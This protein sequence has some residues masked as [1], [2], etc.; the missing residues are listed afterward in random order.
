[1]KKTTS[2][3][4]IS[5]IIALAFILWGVVF[6]NNLDHVTALIQGFL[7]NQ[8]GWFYLLAAT[9]FVAFSIYLIFSPYGRIKLG[10]PDEKPQYSFLT[11]F[12]F[13]FTAGMGIGLVFWGAAEPI[14]HF[15]TPFRA[16]PDTNQAAAEAIQYSMFHWGIH[17]WA[18]YSVVA[19]CLA[20]F[21]FRKDEPAIFSSTLRPIAGNRVDGGLGTTI[22]V[23]VVIA[24]IFGVATSL[25]FGA[26][27][28]SG[29]LGFL[30]PAITNM[31]P[32][33]LNL[34]V[35]IVVTILFSVSAI[36]G[37]DKGIRYLSN[38]NVYLAIALM[39]FI[40]FAGSTAYMMGVFTQG[41]GNYLQNFINM[42][43]SLDIYDSENTWIQD[44]TL[45][46]WAWW[47]SWS[48]FV[49]SFIARVSRG[50]TIR[51]FVIGVIAVPALFGALWFS[52]FG[53]AAIQLERL[54]SNFGDMITSSGEE[55]ALF[56]LLEQFPLTMFVSI[57]ALI[58]IASFFVTSADSAT[59]V[60]GM[61]TTNGMLNPPNIVKLVW[62]LIISGT[63]AVL[64]TSEQGLTAL[65]TTAII[66]AFPFTFIMILMVIALMKSLGEEKPLLAQ[67]KERLRQERARL[68]SEQN[69]LKEEKE[70]F[71]KAKIDSLKNKK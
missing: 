49:G 40:L 71:R 17:P 14:S 25:G 65:Q 37:I 32:T 43:F 51:E 10:K 30:F 9:A 31:N 52:V 27:Q 15:H 64:L 62:G 57:V 2:V 34:I 36:S 66:G 60:L 4:T 48:P 58:L 13:L 8:L 33:L 61:Q 42:S 18:I 21:Q 23:F 7:T 29:G 46:Y 16:D 28:I 12:A 45:F 50:R 67:D 20:Y 1:M 22:N 24:T 70:K 19:L 3:F 47:I 68:K 5:I 38:L 53:G 41:I 35:I 39:L 63:A 59:V 69:K 56:A 11:W 55:V 6:P 54:G 26:A 44:W